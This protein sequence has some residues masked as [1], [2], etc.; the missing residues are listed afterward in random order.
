MVS[1][2]ITCHHNKA[3]GEVIETVYCPLLYCSPVVMANTDGNQISYTDLKALLEKSQNLF[4]VDVR[5]KE[6]I[7][8]G[9][10]PGSLHVPVDTVET[11]F[12]LDAAEFQAKYGVAKPSLD[13]P[14]LV[15]HCQMG[16]RGQLATDKAIALGFQSARNYT[17]GYKEWS[18]KEGK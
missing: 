2:P 8:K 5:T 10:I 13:A 11:A 14:E 18:E 6:E 16:R 7:D 1:R 9:R 15:F 4:I 12:A 3:F 17:G